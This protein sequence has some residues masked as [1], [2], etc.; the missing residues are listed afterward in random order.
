VGRRALMNSPRYILSFTG[1]RLQ[2]AESVALAELFREYG[3]WDRV[4]REAEGGNI[5]QVRTLSSAKRVARELVFRLQE[6]SPRELDALLSGSRD[7]QNHLLW[8]A[9]CR[10]YRLIAEF[11]LEVVRE[12]FLSLGVPLELAD[13]DAFYFRKAD[14]HEELDKLKPVTRRKLRQVLFGMMREAGLITDKGAINPVLLGSEVR[15]AIAA[16][17]PDDLRLFP[18]FETD[19]ARRA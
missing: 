8:V 16:T 4:R 2:R 5:L 18:M 7:D 6:L 10:R 14:W 11:A 15:E 9:I 17:R 3:D 13:F 19:T 1:A 12:R